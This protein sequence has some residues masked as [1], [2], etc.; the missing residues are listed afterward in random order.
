MDNLSGVM[1]GSVAENDIDAM[2]HLTMSDPDIERRWTNAA[3]VAVGRA[4]GRDWWWAVNLARKAIGG[5]QYLNGK[6]LL[7]GVSARHM[8]LHD[9]LDAC[10]MMLWTGCD[11]N[12]RTRLDTELSMLPAG[13]RIRQS[14][15]QKKAMLAAFAAD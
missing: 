3:R 15:E 12:G 6:L 14:A 2:Y 8:P 1:P 11:D 7:S 10:Y 5:W 4:A 13:V 9:W